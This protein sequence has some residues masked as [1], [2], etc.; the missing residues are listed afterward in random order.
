MVG[1]AGQAARGS[2]RDGRHG[3]TT[4]GTAPPTVYD[5]A[6]AA[7]VS[8][9]TVS[10][11]LRTPDAVREGTRDR[12]QAAIRSLGYVPSG[13]ARA[14][15]GRRTGV[16]GL[17]LPG[18]D[19]VPDERPDV[20]TDGG[21]RIVDDRRHVT[22]PTSSNLYFDEVLRGAETEAWQ[23]GLALMV[24]AGRGPSRDVIV[25]DVAGRVDGLAVLAQTVPDELL[26][27][28]ARRIPVVVLADDRRSRGFDSISVDNAA[29]MR[30]LAAHVI[31]RLG[32]RSIAYVAGPVDSPDDQERTAGFKRALEDHGLASA[33]VRTVHGDFGRVRARELA[34]TLLDE[35]VPRAIVCSND[36]S[37][38]GVLDAVL[39][40]GLRVPDD[41]VVT[42]F[43]GIDAGRYSVPRLTTVHQ[44]MGD[45][46]RAA[47]R[48]IVDRL[49]RR[50][51]PPRAVRLPVEVLLRESC[52][53]SI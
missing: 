36:Q 8:I 12:V 9:A 16:V 25:N 5:V 51:G 23:R 26:E 45:L 13:N 43:D 3:V 17:L 4:Q 52:P 42:G 18:F 30:T 11:V 39:A 35:R 50:D 41:V 38:L 20:V 6:S 22:Q 7:G 31:G 29:G 1:V 27:H 2:D 14:L 33:A 40:R 19:V 24:A 37:A 53:P 48:A 46:G 47:V 10:R 34:R 21:V 15:A 44:P 49:D 32:I 28:V